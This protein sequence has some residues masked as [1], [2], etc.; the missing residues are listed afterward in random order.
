[1]SLIIFFGA[2]GF[3]RKR[4]VCDSDAIK[5]TVTSNYTVFTTQVPCGGTRPRQTV[6]ATHRHETSESL[7]KLDGGYKLGFQHQQQCR[8]SENIV[9]HHGEGSKHTALQCGEQ[10]PPVVWTT[11]FGSYRLT[12]SS[13]RC[14]CISKASNGCTMSYFFKALSCF[15]QFVFF[16]Q[17]DMLKSAN[18]DAEA[19]GPVWHAA[20]APPPPPRI[21]ASE[22]RPSTLPSTFP[23]NTAPKATHT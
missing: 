9:T 7:H 20:P 21:P 3:S 19:Y 2:T 5:L 4:E 15:L 22:R 8:C 17:S 1:M 6:C 12:H 16:T 11:V 18:I 23:S 13:I 14:M 10:L